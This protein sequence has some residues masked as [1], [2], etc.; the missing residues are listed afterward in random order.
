[1]PCY[2]SVSLLPLDKYMAIIDV[3]RTCGSIEVDAALLSVWS[4]YFAAEI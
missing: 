3:H 2:L 4:G 1:M